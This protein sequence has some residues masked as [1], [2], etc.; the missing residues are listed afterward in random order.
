[1][2]GI[3]AAETLLA[4]ASDVPIPA[5]PSG[6]S[7]TL[8]APMGASTPPPSF[9]FPHIAGILAFDTPYLGI[10]PGVIAYGAESHVRA[11]SS[12]WS[13][14]SDVAS[15][16][17]YSKAARSATSPATSS[18]NATKLLPPPVAS[19]TKDD[20]AAVPTWQRWGKV[21]MFAGAAGAVAAGGA[22]AY[23]KRD[24]ISEGFGWV[25][26]HLE[27]VNCL[28]RPE[29]LRKRLDRVCKL[30]KD[31]QIEFRD[32]V[33]VVGTDKGA[34]SASEGDISLLGTERTFCNLP[35]PSSKNSE[36]FE[37]T[38]N[39]R[40]KHETAAHM[41]MF[42]RRTNTGYFSLANRARDLLVEWAKAGEW[43]KDVPLDAAPFPSASNSSET[44][45]KEDDEQMQHNETN[46]LLGIVPLDEED[47]KAD[48]HKDYHDKGQD[49]EDDDGDGTMVD[50]DL[51]D[52]HDEHPHNHS[53]VQSPS[54][55]DPRSPILD[56]NDNVWAGEEP[57][58]VEK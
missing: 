42:N 46:D 31:G 9:I 14:V 45:N 37:F 21:A 44:L 27:F 24:T 28:A 49:H 6:D 52:D 15:A 7:T 32:V 26:S 29:D 50:I 19:S 43:F 40:P 25:S 38:R 10:S 34:R 20:A 13:S 17:G 18:T 3:V 23:L 11:A 36:Y 55:T 16:F 5:S 47:G 22:A 35:P 54:I 30:Q 4:I 1:M 58:F 33:T 57:V 2:G 48:N 56:H 41:E 51:N 12:A 39:E 8:S 53:A